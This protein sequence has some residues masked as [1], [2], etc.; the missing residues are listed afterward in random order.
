MKWYEA[1]ATTNACLNKCMSE[2]CVRLGKA[3]PAKNIMAVAA[4]AAGD[5]A[6]MEN[7]SLSS[8]QKVPAY[9]ALKASMKAH[10]AKISNITLCK[11][12][13]PNSKSKDAAQLKLPQISSGRLPSVSIRA[14]PRNTP[15]ICT[16]SSPPHQTSLVGHHASQQDWSWSCSMVERRREELDQVCWPQAW[17]CL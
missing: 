1:P 3:L 5:L 12:T 11:K 7:N 4:D 10:I 17:P 16:A 2:E 13:A 8:T 9:E 6:V 14:T 15:A